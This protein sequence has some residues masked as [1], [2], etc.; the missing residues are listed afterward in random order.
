MPKFNKG[1]VVS[2]RDGRCGKVIFAGIT[3]SEICFSRGKFEPCNMWIAN[4]DLIKVNMVDAD[5]DLEDMELAEIIMEE[6]K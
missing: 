3:A 4:I 2:R 1:D 6:M 5:F